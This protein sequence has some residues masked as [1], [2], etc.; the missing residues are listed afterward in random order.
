MSE[1]VCK[2]CEHPLSRHYKAADDSIRCLV[3][4][5]GLSSSGIIGMPYSRS[6]DCVNGVSKA[7]TY[8]QS[9]QRREDAKRD[10]AIQKIVEAAGEKL[11]IARHKKGEPE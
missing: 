9:R 10:A 7:S 3:T 2:G 4:D 6:C 8:K 1:Q 11:R 5:S